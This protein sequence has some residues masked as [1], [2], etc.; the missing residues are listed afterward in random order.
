MYAATL[1]D[2]PIVVLDGGAAAIWVE[3]CAATARRSPSAWPT[4]TGAPVDEIRAADVDAFVER[5]GSGA[6][7]SRRDP[8]GG[9]ARIAAPAILERISQGDA[10]MG[11][12]SMRALIWRSRLADWWANVWRWVLMAAGAVAAVY[13]VLD[14]GVANAP[15]MGDRRRRARD[16]RGG[17]V[18]GAARD[19]ADGDAGPAHRRSASASAAAICRCRM[20]RSPRRSACAVLLGKRP[21]QQAVARAALA[22]PLLPV[23]DA[24]HGDRESVR[25]EHVRVVPRVAA[26]LG[27][28]R[29]RVGPGRGGLRAARAVAAR[30][31]GLRARRDH[32]R[33]RRHPVRCRGTSAPSTSPGRS[34]CTRTS[35]A[36]PWR[37]PRSSRT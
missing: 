19:R 23:H 3:A 21:V 10:V 20:S 37:S 14:Q 36:R 24:V 5:A 31:H 7:C 28:P 26:R 18:V 4:A 8:A 30:G 34:A 32:D 17:D 15:M 6:G 2:G 33:A 13:I 1:P 9:A 25:G 35:S 22:Q 27:R 12:T 16:R 11:T 29:R